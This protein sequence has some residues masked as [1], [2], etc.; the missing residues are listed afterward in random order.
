MLGRHQ[1]A[2]WAWSP[3]FHTGDSVESIKEVL[4]LTQGH[5]GG[6]NTLVVSVGWLENQLALRNTE[7]S[8]CLTRFT[9]YSVV[10]KQ[11]EHG[12]L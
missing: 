1:R 5:K 2:G 3:T 12:R 7:Q 8:M 10:D 4:P 6:N 9:V 11:T